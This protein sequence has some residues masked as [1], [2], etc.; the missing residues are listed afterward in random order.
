MLTAHQSSLSY[1]SLGEL[2]DVICN[3]KNWE[4]FEKYF[5]PKDNT[6]ARIQEIKNIRNRIMHFREP[7]E[8]D[9]ARVSLFLKDF[10]SGV[11]LF[12]QSYTTPV[13]RDKED[14]LVTLLTAHWDSLDMESNSIIWIVTIFMLPN[15]IE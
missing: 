15:P 12:C 7:H 13:I 14:E 2:W 3:K 5:P 4:L 8:N 11:R 10:E 9:V 6:I 1:L